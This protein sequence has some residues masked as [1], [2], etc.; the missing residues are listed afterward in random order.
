MSVLLQSMKTAKYV[1][2]PEGWTEHPGQARE[3][4]G[5]TDALIYCYNHHLKNMQILGSFDDPRE[6][7]TIPL[8]EMGRSDPGASAD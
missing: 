3:F 7:F 2:Q 1:E 5:A 4:R 6:N 8:T